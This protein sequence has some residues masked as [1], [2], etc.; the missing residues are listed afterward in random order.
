MDWF[1]SIFFPLWWQ[2]PE[3]LN[4]NT[5][6]IRS[7]LSKTLFIYNIYLKISEG[8]SI[9]QWYAGYILIGALFRSF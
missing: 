4:E 8:I 7:T 5:E 3:E 1:V 6:N 2:N 9:E